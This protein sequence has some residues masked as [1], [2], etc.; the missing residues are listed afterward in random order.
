MFILIEIFLNVMNVIISIEK[1]R[2]VKIFI[3]EILIDEF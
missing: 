2:I 1:I 3:L